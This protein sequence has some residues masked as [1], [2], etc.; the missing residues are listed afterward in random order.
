MLYKSFNEVYFGNKNILV[1]FCNLNFKK[2]ELEN[3]CFDCGCRN[4]ELISIN[5]GILIVELII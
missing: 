2:N 4:P 3:N 5:N 1:S